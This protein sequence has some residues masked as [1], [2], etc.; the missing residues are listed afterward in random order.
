V[1][2]ASEISRRRFLKNA[3]VVGVGLT[4][5][6]HLPAQAAPLPPP[7]KAG[8][9]FALKFDA[10][11]IVSLRRVSDSF[12][13]DYI[14]PNH[15]LGDVVLTFRRPDGPWQTVKT[16]ALGSS[17]TAA[18]SADGRQYTV[19]YQVQNDQKPALSLQLHFD[20]R[21]GAVVW[22]MTLHNT[23]GQPLEVGDLA[24][25]LPLNT[26][27][28]A[29]KPASASVLK[30]SF[31]SGH[32]SYLFWM[33]SNSVGPYLMLTPLDGTSLEYWDTQGGYR[34]FIHSAVVGAAAKELGCRWRQPH[35]NLLLAPAGQAGDTQ[36]YGFKFG[37]ANDYAGVWQLLLVSAWSRNSDEAGARTRSE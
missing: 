6:S 34:M 17:R 35:T 22:T 4:L 37:W 31:I 28:D 30:H 32:G 2:D 20:V 9:A 36:A 11:A 14:Q 26:H 21:D 8:P 25:P 1:P 23:S 3:G 5:G 33:R 7:E 13:T 15:R 10:G 19:T 16:S 24:L 12:D 18:L 27:F 29:G